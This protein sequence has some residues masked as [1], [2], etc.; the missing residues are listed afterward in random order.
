VV[1]LGKATKALAYR[2]KDDAA[3]RS[4]IEKRVLEKHQW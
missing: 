4:L 1:V 3:K 2:W